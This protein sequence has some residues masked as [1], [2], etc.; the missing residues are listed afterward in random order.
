MYLEVEGKGPVSVSKEQ[1]SRV[2]DMTLFYKH[3]FEDD[4]SVRVMFKPSADNRV[5]IMPKAF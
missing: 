2:G 3:T 4:A 5:I 1:A